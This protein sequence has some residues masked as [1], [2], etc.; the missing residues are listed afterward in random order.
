MNSMSVLFN[1]FWCGGPSKWLWRTRAPLH[2]VHS[3]ACISF[4]AMLKS[5]LSQDSYFRLLLQYQS[6]I[7]N[8][9]FDMSTKIN[10]IHTDPNTIVIITIA[11]DSV[12]FGL[13][14]LTSGN[15][16]RFKAIDYGSDSTFWRQDHLPP[17]RWIDRSIDQCRMLDVFTTH[18]RFLWTAI[19]LLILD[20]GHAR[21]PQTPVW[22][23]LV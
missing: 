9:R 4:P 22:K 2:P 23:S 21:G 16:F 14:A 11:K 19:N 17:N 18:L 5:E 12:T 1:T 6:W 20:R 13:A 15:E 8:N 3:N 7:V 10:F